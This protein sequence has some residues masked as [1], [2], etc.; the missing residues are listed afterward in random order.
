MILF[1]NLVLK[2]Y[3]FLIKSRKRLKGQSWN[4]LKSS[5]TA[6][7]LFTTERLTILPGIEPIIVA[8]TSAIVEL[9]TLLPVLVVVPFDLWR[10][11]TIDAWPGGLGKETDV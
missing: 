2:Q 4:R 7:V 5:L 3:R 11:A 10:P 6:R 9:A 1:H 8:R